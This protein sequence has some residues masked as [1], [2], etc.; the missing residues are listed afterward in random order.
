MSE[1]KQKTGKKGSG[2]MDE[3]AKT[4]FAPIYPVIAENIIRRFGI[5]TG[6]CID[7]GSGPALLSIAI[8]EMSDLSVT[9]LDYSNEMHEAASGNIEEAGLSDRI[10]LMCGDVHNIPLDDDYADLIISRGS[11]FFWDDIHQAF[12]EIYRILKP[13]GKTYIGG[14]FGNKELFES[15]SAKMIRKNPKWKEF[16]RKNISE[17]NVTRFKNMLEDIGVPDY[18]VILGDEGFWIII[19]KSVPGVLK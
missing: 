19:S 6:I 1:N 14:G 7:L 10:T 8:A 5:K 2:N 4:I 15:V 16:N 3:I 13:G 12:K 11:M 9:A 17:E 18:E